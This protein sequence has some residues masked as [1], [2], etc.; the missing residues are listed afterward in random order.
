MSATAT[1]TDSS[2]ADAVCGPPPRTVSSELEEMFQ[3]LSD[4]ASF[5]VVARKLLEVAN[6]EECTS[7][8]LL[9]VIEQDP[10]LALKILQTVNSAYYGLPN[11]VADLK[12]AITML[13]VNQVRNMALTVVVGRHY[14][15]PSSVG[16][17]DP[18]QMW[19]HSVCTA[20]AARMVAEKTG[21]ANGDEAYLAGLI[22][23]AGLLVI[24]QKMQ[25]DMPRIMARFKATKSWTDSEQ[26]VLAFD[27]AQ[28]GAYIAW[29]SGFP[30]RLVAAVD[31]H[32]CP[33]EASEEVAPLS[34]VVAVSN[35]LVS[36]LGRSVM[37]ERR[38]P[39]PLQVVFER[40]HLGRREVRE[41][42]AELERVLASIGELKNL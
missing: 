29:R 37:A 19:D 9:D 22:H 17:I 20:A 38:L 7:A 33:T 26:E 25:D 39:P 34:S 32:H 24:D 28:L 6:D 14:S 16:T 8:D 10:V 30:H 11:N 41:L 42:W 2:T 3:R 21:A 15:K 23:D 13:G 35:Y 40:I 27:H 31:Y 5:P 12:T 1:Q 18:L 4:I 36:R